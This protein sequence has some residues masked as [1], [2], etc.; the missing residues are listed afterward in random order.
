MKIK[1]KEA[2]ILGATS[3]E[4]TE[5]DHWSRNDKYDGDLFLESNYKKHLARHAN[6]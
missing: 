5:T 2:K 1:M 3:S 6:K 4:P